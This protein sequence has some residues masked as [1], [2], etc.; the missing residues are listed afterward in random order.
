M[1]KIILVIMC[2][3]LKDA[4]ILDLQ[5]NMWAVQLSSLLV[6]KAL[7]VYSGLLSEVACDFDKLQKVL[8]Y[9]GT[10]LLS[11]ALVRDFSV[12]N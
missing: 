9:R 1:R 11:K 12:R 8:F 3:G 4:T 7:D 2:C 6:S 10:I 5:W